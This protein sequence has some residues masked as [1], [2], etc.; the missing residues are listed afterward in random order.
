MAPHNEPLMGDKGKQ[1]TPANLAA[2]VAAGLSIALILSG[3]RSATVCYFTDARQALDARD[4]FLRLGKR[5]IVQVLPPL[6]TLMVDRPELRPALG[7][8]RGGDVEPSD[9]AIAQ[10]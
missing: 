7:A 2:A 4:R 6:E 3:E 10:R 9:P 1:L 8:R 5:P